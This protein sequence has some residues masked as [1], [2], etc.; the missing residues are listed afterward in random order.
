MPFRG[1][2]KVEVTEKRDLTHRE[3]A[4]IFSLE[5]Y[6]T[7]SVLIAIILGVSALIIYTQLIFVRNALWAVFVLFILE[8]GLIIGEYYMIFLSIKFHSKIINIRRELRYAV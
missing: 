8:L 7:T 6:F 3:L 4:N 1:K 2:E 5:N